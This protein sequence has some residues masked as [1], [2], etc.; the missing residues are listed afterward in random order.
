M[1]RGSLKGF[2]GNVTRVIRLKDSKREYFIKGHDDTTFEEAVRQSWPFEDHD[3]HKKWRVVSS[4][5]EDLT[6]STLSSH[7]R[8]VILEFV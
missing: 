6:R 3:V 5:G 8:T 4:T 7:E 1:R 2:A